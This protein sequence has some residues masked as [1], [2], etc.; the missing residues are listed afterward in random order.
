MISFKKAAEAEEN[1]AVVFA[2][3][4]FQSKVH[5]DQ[6]NK[7]VMADPRLSKMTNPNAMPFDCKEWHTVVLK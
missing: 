3:I 5:H 7:A 4:V 1:E 2:W 6:V